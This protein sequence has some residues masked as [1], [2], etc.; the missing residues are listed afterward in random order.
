M[1]ARIYTPDATGRCTVCGRPEAEHSRSGGWAGDEA[2]CMPVCGCACCVEHR[3]LIAH[4]RERPAC[5]CAWY[6]STEQC[7]CA[8]CVTSRVAA[9]ES[10]SVVIHLMKVR[11]THR[12]PV[13]MCGALMRGNNDRPETANCPDCASAAA[14]NAR[15]KAGR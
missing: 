5:N 7:D 9:D 15:A 12:P 1:T 2:R 14:I 13:A 10:D 3:N 4:N 6:D 11:G 8:F